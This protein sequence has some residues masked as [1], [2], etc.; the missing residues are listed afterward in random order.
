MEIINNKEWAHLVQRYSWV[1][2]MQGVPQDVRHHA[3]GDVAVHTRMVLEALMSLPEY[4][5][6]DQG[7]QEVIW[8]A[9]LLHDVEKRSTTFQEKDGS[10]VSP[11]HAK[12]GAMT[13]RQILLTEL[14]VPFAIREQIVGLV[15]YHGLPLWVMYKP[16]PLKALLEASLAV[17]TAWLCLLAKADILGR[18]CADGA[19]ML[20]RISFFEAYCREQECFGVPRSFGS[21][22]ARFRYFTT[23]D[24]SPLYVPYEAPI[25]EVTLLSGLPGMGKD[26]YIRRYCHDLPV[27]SLDGIR[28]IHKI[29]PDDKSATGWVAQHAKEQARVHLRA[30]QDFVWNATNITRQMRSQLIALFADYGAR[31]KVVYIEKPYKIWQAQNREREHAVPATV[32]NKLLLKLEVPVKSEAHEVVYCVG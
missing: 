26:F 1:C 19:E 28:H 2:D 11:G 7:A 9:A 13:A 20:E 15:R 25:C 5:A 4:R 31:V 32:L 17:N 27:V 30:R 3:E 8:I 10:I 29:R 21:D 6:L 16:D 22:T 12:K 24:A 18:I 14:D 23:E